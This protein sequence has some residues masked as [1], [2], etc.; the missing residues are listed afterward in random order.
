ML[1]A[2]VIGEHLVAFNNYDESSYKVYRV[3]SIYK[4]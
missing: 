3:E 4:G 2:I 1:Y